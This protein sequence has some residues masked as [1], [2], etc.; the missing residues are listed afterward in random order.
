MA[1]S[2]FRIYGPRG[3]VECAADVIVE[4]ARTRNRR[5]SA[6]AT[7]VTAIMTHHVVCALPDL[8]LAA[9]LEVMVSE[10]LGCVPVVDEHGHPV[11]MVTKFDVVENLVA[12]PRLTSPSVADVMMP[13]AI[14]LDD[15][16][17]VEHAAALMASEDMH[18]V[19][20][21][22]E[23]RLVG[24]ISTMDVTRWLASHSREAS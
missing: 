8:P 16:D 24:I 11:G 2:A 14:T 9:M 21:V 13:L 17:T 1:D 15:D 4:R 12:P 22:A 23:R 6:A 19:M 3:I 10:R 5:R 20:I 18:H 7:P